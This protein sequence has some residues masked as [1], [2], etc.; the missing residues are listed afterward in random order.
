VR[1]AVA[2]KFQIATQQIA[3]R[4]RAKIADVREIPHRRTAQIHF[5]FVVLQR[6]KIFG[7]VC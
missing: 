7:F 3:E 4:K 2:F 1:Y 5:D 6:Y